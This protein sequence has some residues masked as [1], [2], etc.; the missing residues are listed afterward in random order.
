MG[1]TSTFGASLV[2][3][4]RFGS[5]RINEFFG[6]GGVPTFDSLGYTDG[7]GRGAD[8]TSPVPGRSGGAFGFGCQ[9]LGDADFQSSKQGTYQWYDG[10]SKIVKSHTIKWGVEY[11]DVYSNNYTNFVF[12]RHFHLQRFHR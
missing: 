9:A 11:R 5:N 4:F 10:M 3:E 8:F 12:P 1:L 7:E 2:N 6:C